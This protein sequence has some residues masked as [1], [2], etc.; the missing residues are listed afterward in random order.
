[1]PALGG[2][3]PSVDDGSAQMGPTRMPHEGF[4]TLAYP[5]FPDQRQ[6]EPYCVVGSTRE[7]WLQW[8]NV[9]RRHR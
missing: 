4:T 2:M 6:G 9:P 1:M 8:N 7:T 3:E 5:E